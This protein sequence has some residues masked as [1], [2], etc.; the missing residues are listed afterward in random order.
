MSIKDTDA[1]AKPAVVKPLDLSNLLRDAFWS[2]F[3]IAGG[4]P[5]TI[6]Q[7]WPDYDPE[8]CPAYG[9]IVAAV[10]VAK[11]TRPAPAPAAEG[12][13][14]RVGAWMQACFGP[15]ISADKTERNHRFLEEALELVQANGCT[16]SEAAQLVAYVY[17]RQSGEL[18]QEIGGVMVTLAAL[19][20]AI[21]EDMDAAGETELARIWTKVEQIR[22]KQAA[23]PKH[24]PLPTAPAAEKAEAEPP[25]T[26]PFTICEACGKPDLYAHEAFW[27]D[28]GASFCETCLPAPPALA[29][30]T[31]E[32]DRLREANDRYVIWSHEHSAWWRPESR[33][34]AKAIEDAGVYDRDEAL[35]ICHNARD[36]W[37]PRE[38]PTE[39]P[40]RI[41]DL[42][43]FARAALTDGGSNGAS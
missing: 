21:G 33:G 10:E 43:E 40:I 42:P 11:N 19:C 32:R 15:E 8:K 31:A 24:S 7:W 23:K 14:P 39:L 1:G 18:H 34:Y 5:T 9:R 3:E 35:L 28:D 20:L 12:L 29:S 41:S 2:G 6:D 25:G 27:T 36:G 26:G 4:D 22:A 37:H 17:G 30:L 13:Q 16:E 38:A